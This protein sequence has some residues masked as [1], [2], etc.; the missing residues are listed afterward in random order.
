MGQGADGSRTVSTSTLDVPDDYIQTHTTQLLSMYK[1]C[2]CIRGPSLLTMACQCCL[3][4]LWSLLP[5]SC[6]WSC[7]LLISKGCLN[8]ARTL[9]SISLFCSSFS[10]FFFFAAFVSRTL[11]SS[12]RRLYAPPVSG[13]ICSGWIPC[14]RSRSR[15]PCSPRCL[16]LLGLPDKEEG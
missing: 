9:S 1:V 6:P 11:L 3:L 5:W 13:D 10:I 4:P 14:S 16:S 2:I 7:P 12:E 15:S 8:S